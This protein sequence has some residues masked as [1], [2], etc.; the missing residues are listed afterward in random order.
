MISELQERFYLAGTAS[1][2]EGAGGL[3]AVQLQGTDGSSAVVYLHGGHVT[4][5][6]DSSGHQNLFLS[7]QAV[8]QPGKAIR[9]GIPICFPQFGA[10]PL[11]QH[12]F[13]RTTDWQLDHVGRTHD[14]DAEV[15]LSLTE[16]PQSLAL[17]PHRF[18]AE[19]R[20]CLGARALGLHLGVLNTDDQAF[21]FQVALHTYFSVPD[22]SQ[23]AVEGLRGVAFVDSL[24]DDQRFVEDRDEIEFQAETDRI[25]A[26]APDRLGVVDRAA[27]RVVSIDKLN[28]PDAVVWNP[29]VEKAKRMEDFGDTEYLRMV[30]VETAVIE[31][32]I[33]LESGGRYQGGAV[34]TVSSR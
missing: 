27:G 9:G 6:V 8:F 33:E 11:P 20:V 1:V 15:L 34:L 5:W 12:G 19:L 3:P 2:F 25:Y 13:A 26:S 16:S 4:S 14:G 21:S 31:N 10:G 17:W 18:R 29:W 32:P 22:I 23:A 7:E 24:R 30:C 28:M